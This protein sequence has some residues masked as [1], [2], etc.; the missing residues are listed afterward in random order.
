MYVALLSALT[1]GLFGLFS[2]HSKS[3]IDGFSA[4]PPHHVRQHSLA[5]PAGLSPA[6][7]KA[8][9]KLPAGDTVGG[10][11]TIAI[12]D[13]YD[14]PSI[15]SDLSTFSSQFKLPACTSYNGCFE[16]HKMSSRLR[17]D[18]GWALEIALDVEWAHA[19]APGAKILL[20]EAR[21]SSGND[22]LSAVDYARSRP[23]VKAVSMSWGGSEF[24][25]QDFYD[26]HFTS[27]YGAAFFAASGDNGSGAGWPAVSSNVT[28]VGGTTLNL[29]ADG[30]VASETAWSGSGGGISNYTSEPGYQQALV[31]NSGGMRGVPDVSYDADPGT[32]FAVYDGT[33]YYGQWGWW[34]VGGTS[35]GTPQW[36]AIYEAGG[37]AKN[38]ALY[39][40]A[41][42]PSYASM[43]RDIKSGSNGSCGAVCVAGPG[44]DFVTGLGSPLSI[45][46]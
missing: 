19:I 31:T 46:F 22:L 41:A 26:Y 45:N 4:A 28:G 44:Y 34:Q 35:A 43:L 38:S 37:T 9:Y 7:T 21:S 3:A 1:L 27:N 25:G 23:D 40:D 12:V 11:G 42:G 32:G 17:A 15:A 29:A 24:P 13:A 5:G 14:S 16:K 8:A 36:A 18:G 10:G 2:P 6:Q 20:V 30:S 39:H 33:S